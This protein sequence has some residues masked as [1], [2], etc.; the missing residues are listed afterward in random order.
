MTSAA[1]ILQA[2]GSEIVSIDPQ[3]SVYDALALMNQ[4]NIGALLVL[5]QGR[6]VGVISERDYA[7][8]IALQGRSSKTTAVL[9]IMT[10]DY[11]A[12]TPNTPVE[13]C[14]GIMTEKRVRHLPVIDGRQLLG[15]VSIGDV[16][17]AMIDDRDFTIAQLE[18]YI[19]S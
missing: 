6:L 2:K 10:S 7:R 13:E 5:Q 15:I 18:Q 17:K 4:R 9:D 8:K 11:I 3:A 16:V 1:E 14:M 19:S 12:V